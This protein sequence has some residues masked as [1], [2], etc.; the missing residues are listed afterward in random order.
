MSL[1]ALLSQLERE[2]PIAFSLKPRELVEVLLLEH[3]ATRRWN[4]PWRTS[5]WDPS[6]YY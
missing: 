5:G 6:D 1:K 3:Q 2:N 4:E